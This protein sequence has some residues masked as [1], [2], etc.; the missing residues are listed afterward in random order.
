MLQARDP[1]SMPPAI[2]ILIVNWNSQEEL[3][4]CLSTVVAQTGDQDQVVVVDNGSHDESCAAVRRR[5]PGVELVEAGE[6]LGFA[7]G[8]NRGIEQASGAWIFTLNNDAELM[9]GCLER[10]RDTASRAGQR[11]GMLQPKMLFRDAPE[12]L[13]STGVL[14]FREGKASDRD[15]GTPL[16]EHRPSPDVFCVTA[17]AALYR[18]SML[19]AV[20]LSTG[21]FDRTFFMYFEDVDLGWRCRL[22][23]WSARYVDDAAVLHGFQS[24]SR[25][26]GE[27]WVERH[28]K[29]NRLRML[30]KN[31]SYG[32]LLRS[33]PV[34]LSDLGWLA[35][36][37]GSAGVRDAAI[38]V[39][40]G[41]ATRR[42]VGSRQQRS[43]R[44]V[45]ER[46]VRHY[47]P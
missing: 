7:E 13:N 24:S 9:E 5:F 38:A 15:F 34:S 16:A 22:A 45:E 21:V 12:Q 27:R 31:A 19:D 41:L 14:L 37:E 46:W 20:G 1:S 42:E 30:L 6:N 28:C 26:R 3:L 25:R 47:K 4:Q 43:R 44:A 18:K 35:L 33:V 39:R 36:R 32:M 17:G 10:L 8:C 23:G 11:V 29:L 40:D 2:T